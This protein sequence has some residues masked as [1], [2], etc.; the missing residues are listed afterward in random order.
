MGC[1][2]LCR[3]G[4]FTAKRIAGEKKKVSYLQDRNRE[5]DE[6]LLR[7]SEVGTR[8]GGAFLPRVGRIFFSRSASRRGFLGM[9]PN[10]EGSGSRV[11]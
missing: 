9:V 2:L 5:P 11:I 8:G 7:C 10:A 6:Y 4:Y 3:L 1:R